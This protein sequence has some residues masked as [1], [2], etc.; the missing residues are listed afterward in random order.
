MNSLYNIKHGL[1]S[2][3]YW[4]PII[5]HWRPWDWAYTVDVL[6]HSLEAQRDLEIKYQRHANWERQARDLSICI[7]ALR[8]LRE[9]DEDDMLELVRDDGPGS[10]LG[11]RLQVRP[12]APLGTKKA[13]F[14]RNRDRQKTYLE[15]AT[16]QLRRHLLQWWD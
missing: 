10:I 6:I 11:Q 15:L 5:W 1:R 8:R 3:W 16:S 9:D 14:A 4:L 13:V 7:E 2:L 12:D